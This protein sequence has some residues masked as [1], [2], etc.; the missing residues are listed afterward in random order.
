MN[1]PI[2]VRS[3]VLAVAHRSCAIVEVDERGLA[4]VLSGCP[5]PSPEPDSCRTIRQT[6]SVR[7]AQ[8]IQK[9]SRS[10][11]A[12]VLDRLRLS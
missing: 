7:A 10:D 6:G 8:P 3:A 1:Y 5:D 12:G 11:A 9:G 4:D 2:A